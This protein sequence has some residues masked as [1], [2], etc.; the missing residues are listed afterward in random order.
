MLT[1]YSQIKL[2]KCW[3][4]LITTDFPLD[5]HGVTSEKHLKGNA[6]PLPHYDD[7]REIRGDFAG[8]YQACVTL[9]SGQSNYYGWLSLADHNG[10]SVYEAEL[11]SFDDLSMEVDGVTYEVTAE[12]V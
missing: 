12:W 2:P 4:D 1:F 7:V 11:E 3:K 6:D 5:L 8:G 10:C 9:C